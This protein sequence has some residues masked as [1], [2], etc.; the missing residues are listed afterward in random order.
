MRAARNVTTSSSNVVIL[1]EI[2]QTDHGHETKAD[3]KECELEH[4][5]LGYNAV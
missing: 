3:A 2:I 4:Y 5:L 1:S